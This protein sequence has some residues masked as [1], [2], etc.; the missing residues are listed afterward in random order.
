MPPLRMAFIALHVWET[1]GRKNITIFKVCH[2]FRFYM[3]IS[4][5][6]RKIE[7]LNSDP[8]TLIFSALETTSPRIRS[9][10]EIEAA[11]RGLS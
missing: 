6:F 3:M 2:Y 9:G 5:S 10:H 8:S 1:V 4:S 11:I 7:N